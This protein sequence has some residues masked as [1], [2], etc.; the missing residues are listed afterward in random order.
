MVTA[1]EKADLAW[2]LPQLQGPGG[3]AP[4]SCLWA[5]SCSMPLPAGAPLW[6]GATWGRP[7]QHGPGFALRVAWLPDYPSGQVNLEDRTAGLMERG[8][9]RTRQRARFGFPSLEHKALGKGKNTVCA[10]TQK[11]MQIMILLAGAFLPSYL[12]SGNGNMH[13][14]GNHVDWGKDDL[15]QFM[16]FPLSCL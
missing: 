4:L 5:P 2:V 10:V 9:Q 1:T 7:A 15:S 6:L 11:W 13:L 14:P 16:P 12:E 3:P 8:P